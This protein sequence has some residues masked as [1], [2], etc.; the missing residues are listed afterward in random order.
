MR[1]ESWRI[2]YQSSE[3]AA[4]AAYAEVKR[5]R[6]ALERLE[7]QPHPTEYL[8]PVGPPADDCPQ[9]DAHFRWSDERGQWEMIQWLPAPATPAPQK[10]DT[11]E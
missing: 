6:A 10:G 3:Q 5:L 11:D 7:R 2:S 9:R 8:D 1:Y 4:R